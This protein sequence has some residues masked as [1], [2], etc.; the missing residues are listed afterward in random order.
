MSDPI[1]DMRELAH[2]TFLTEFQTKVVHLMMPDGRPAVGLAIKEHEHANPVVLVMEP[3]GITKLA[4][5]LSDAAYKI[6]KP[7]MD[8]KGRNTLQ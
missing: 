3:G 4:D 1:E 8:E 5:E 6:L 7:E 2:A